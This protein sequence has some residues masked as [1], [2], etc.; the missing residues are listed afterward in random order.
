MVKIYVD[1]INQGLWTI[2]KVPTV[3]REA[4]SIELNK[5]TA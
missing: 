5:K 3:W 2:D 1:L 4:V